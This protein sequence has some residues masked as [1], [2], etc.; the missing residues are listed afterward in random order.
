MKL[1][2]A[3]Q[4]HTRVEIQN[5]TAALRHEIHIGETRERLK[6]T[7]L[8]L[9]QTRAPFSFEALHNHLREL[10]RC[11]NLGSILLHKNV[12]K[13]LIL[14]ELRLIIVIFLINF[15]GN[16]LDPGLVGIIKELLNQESTGK[17]SLISGVIAIRLAVISLIDAENLSH[18]VSQEERLRGGIIRD[19][20]KQLILNNIKYMCNTKSLRKCLNVFDRSIGIHKWKCVQNGGMEF[21]EEQ[22]C[23]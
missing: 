3:R 18:T 21:G 8:V 19:V 9:S 14:V 23:L 2:R 5:D 1:T 17:A 15:K 7:R 12:L 22:F 4:F 16:D 11:K 6:H 10:T 13:V 20:N